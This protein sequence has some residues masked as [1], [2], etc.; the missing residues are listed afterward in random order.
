MNDTQPLTVEDCLKELR[1]MFP[2]K[3]NDFTDA[4]LSNLRNQPRATIRVRGA[5]FFGDNLD[6]CMSK[7]R[8]WHAEQKKD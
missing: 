8:T 3:P 6:E 7:A 2:D 5:H 4:W 1:E